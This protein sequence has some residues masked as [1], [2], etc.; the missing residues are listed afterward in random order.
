M[1]KETIFAEQ[2]LE[3]TEVEGEVV[4]ATV[5][6]TVPNIAAD[7]TVTI[8]WDGVEYVCKAV[9][10]QEGIIGVGN[11]SIMGAG[12]D[13]G[14]P[15]ALLVIYDP[16]L[17][18]AQIGTFSTD[19]THT[20]AIY[21]EATSA[22]Q[23]VLLDKGK[24]EH[25]F[26][27]DLPLLIP[28]TEGGLRE[29]SYGAALTDMEIPLDLASGNQPLAAPDGYLVKTATILKPDTLLPEN[30]KSGVEIAGV[31]GEYA[32]ETEEATVELDFS[33][34]DMTVKP[35][36]GKFLSRV[37]IPKPETLVPENIAKD[38]NIAGVVGTHE[39]GGGATEVKKPFRFYDPY[40]NV[41]YEYTKKEIQEMTELPEGPTLEGLSF[42]KWT[43][44]LAD[45]K[46]ELYF[47]DVGPVF[48][49]G[50]NYASVLILDVPYNNKSITFVLGTNSRV[51]VTINYGD[52]ASVKSTTNSGLTTF[53]HTYTAAGEYIFFVAHDGTVQ[54]GY[55]NTSGNATYYYDVFNGS[56]RNE[57]TDVS[58]MRYYVKSALLVGSHMGRLRGNVRLRFISFFATDSTIYLGYRNLADCVMLQT[59]AA[60]IHFNTI[61][62][63][64]SL[65]FC[66]SLQRIKLNRLYKENDLIRGCDSLKEIASDGFS[67]KTLNA[68]HALL[69]YSETPPAL[70]GNPTVGEY[71]IYV[72]DESVA[73]YKAADGW[74]NVADYIFPASKY[75]S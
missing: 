36:E 53:T 74:V 70:S 11:L 63:N 27:L 75:H 10:I 42:Y 44:T 60:K 18:S 12:E 8:S 14:E 28:D 43:H 2:E 58:T 57:S 20:V 55:D 29:Y 37:D 33:G 47:A 68:D 25:K 32:L 69:M 48:K 34:G 54:F 1:A 38:V 52:G 72:P 16:D 66:A 19:P 71:P 59:I 62:S 73:A 17:L 26:P 64:H 46:T 39:G 9:Q 4:Y 61:L 22:P 51:S 7:D 40:G 65:S 67:D 50:D 41:I 21:K 35:T 31:V 23:I 56:E 49:Y 45:L 13:S 6:S 30:I 3:F 5:L 24:N 15:F